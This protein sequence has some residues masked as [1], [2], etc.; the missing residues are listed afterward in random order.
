MFLGDDFLLDTPTAVTLYHDYAANAPILDYHCHLPPVEIAENRRFSSI[1]ELWLGGDHYKWRAMRANGVPERLVTG[2]GDDLEKFRAWA[3]TLPAAIGN[4]LYQWAHLE[5][6]RFFGIEE[7]LSPSTADRIYERC[8][9]LLATEEFRARSL[10]KRMGVRGVCTTDD[11]ADDLAY[12]DALAEEAGFDIP[13]LPAF[14]P[15]KAFKTGEPDAWNGWVDTLAAAA[16]LDIGDYDALLRALEKR[17]AFFHE[18]GCRTSDHGLRAPFPL[19][20]DGHASRVFSSARSGNGVSGHDAELFA[21][22]VLRKL[23]EM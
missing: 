7:V 20:D 10:M 1:T 2:D 18:R 3:A 16:D 15:D 23:G 4:P 13:V 21:G 8:N 17:M 22:N 6:R 19:G 9:E 11:P 12:H 14:R 5:L